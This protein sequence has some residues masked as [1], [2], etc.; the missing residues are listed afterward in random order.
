MAAQSPRE[1]TKSYR[2]LD[3]MN[4][5]E[6]MTVIDPSTNSTFHLVA[7]DDRGLCRELAALDAGESVDLALSPAGVRANVWQASRTEN[8]TVRT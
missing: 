4:A 3:E 5:Y 1:G 2:I 8:V 6:T 7:Y